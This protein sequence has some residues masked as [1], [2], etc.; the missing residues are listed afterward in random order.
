MGTLAAPLVYGALLAAKVEVECCGTYAADV[1]RFSAGK[2]YCEASCPACEGHETA[3]TGYKGYDEVA[4]AAGESF[5]YAHP[6]EYE[7][8]ADLPNPVF[9]IKSASSL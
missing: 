4:G 1:I 3:H 9:D 6:T 8:D 5:E 2:A 7:L